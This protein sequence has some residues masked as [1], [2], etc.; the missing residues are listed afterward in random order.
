MSLHSFPP[1]P[2]IF[3]FN[4]SI[5]FKKTKITIRWSAN[6]RFLHFR[7]CFIFI[8]VFYLKKNKN[9]NS[10]VIPKNTY[11][12][13]LLFRALFL[14]MYFFWQEIIK[15]KFSI[16]TLKTDIHFFHFHSY[17][18]F[19]TEFYLKKLS[20]SQFGCHPENIYPFSPL[21]S[22]LYFYISNLFDIKQSK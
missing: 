15:I 18:I 7:L 12:F 3:H 4:I 13:P 1:F 21:L 20:K 16:V 17:C 6:I 19:T 22:K 14:Y 10:I 9:R 5:L 8:S 2:F 11:P